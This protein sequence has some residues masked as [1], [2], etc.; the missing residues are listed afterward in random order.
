[1]ILGQASMNGNIFG[2]EVSMGKRLYD[3]GSSPVLIVKHC[4]GG[5]SAETH[6]NPTSSENSWDRND[7]DGTAKWLLD[8]G[9]AN[10]DSKNHMYANFMY[11]AR[12]ALELL[13]DAGIPHKLSGLFWI[14]GAADRGRGWRE[15]KQDLITLFESFRADLGEPTL[16]IVDASDYQNHELQTGRASAAAVMEGCNVVEATWSL[17]AS[18]PDCNQYPCLKDNLLNFDVLNFYGYDPAMKTP[19][20]FKRKGD[21]GSDKT[22]HWF[23]TWPENQHLAHDGTILQGKMLANAF[24]KGITNH[25]LTTTWLEDDIETQ[26][27]FLPCDPKVNG[28]EP[29]ED[30]IC[31]MDLRVDDDTFRVQGMSCKGFINPNK[32]P[33][34]KLHERCNR[35]YQNGF[36]YDACPKSCDSIFLDYCRIEAAPAPSR[37]PTRKPTSIP[38]PYPTPAPSR[39]PTRNPTS[40]PRPYPTDSH[41]MSCEDDENFRF[42]REVKDNIFLFPK[43][44]KSKCERYLNLKKHPIE[45]LQKRCNREYEDGFVYDACPNSCGK[46]GIGQCVEQTK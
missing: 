37:Y 29:N 7:D 45:K 32:Y 22:F 5:T 11:T 21:G 25:E 33:I 36:V 31:W 4:V 27:P 46:V 16:A 14:Q 39:H 15:Y 26:Y 13:E 19:E 40:I 42:F 34:Q 18:N 6:W 43:E 9:A 2:P 44:R 38:S 28:G 8:N 1:M 23:W 35:K 24:V 3:A 17:V 30:N 41:P 20:I 12:R 10:L